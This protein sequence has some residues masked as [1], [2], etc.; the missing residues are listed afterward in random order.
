MRKKINPSSTLADS[1]RCVSQRSCWNRLNR[2]KRL[3]SWADFFSVVSFFF[4]PPESFAHNTMCC[5]STHQHGH[6]VIIIDGLDY[7]NGGIKYT[8]ASIAL[9]ETVKFFCIVTWT[10]YEN[11]SC[12]WNCTSCLFITTAICSNTAIKLL[13][14]QTNA[15]FI[16]YGQNLALLQVCTMRMCK[17]P[18]LFQR[19]L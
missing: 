1:L 12:A 17:W 3:W 5:H 14:S 7:S 19:C 18:V 8:K 15:G 4:S 11:E 10:C 2:C 6:F 9:N 13:Y 16:W